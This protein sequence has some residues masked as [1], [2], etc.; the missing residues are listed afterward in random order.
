M[1]KAVSAQAIGGAET[2]LVVEDE[3]AILKT[4]TIMLEKSGYTVPA[5]GS[6]SE[7]VSLARQH[8]GILETGTH[9]LQKPFSKN[10]LAIKVRE[11]LD[12]RP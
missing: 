5:A 3:P 9:F 4:C 6:P 8:R 2:V 7:A 1:P 12:S 11:A 10:D